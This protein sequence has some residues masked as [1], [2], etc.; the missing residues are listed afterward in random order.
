ML[1][2]FMTSNDLDAYLT[3]TDSQGNVLRRD[4]NSFGGT[5]SMIL[6]WASAGQTFD[7]GATASLGSQTGRYQVDVLYVAGD[8][9]P[10]CLPMG[11]LGAGTTQGIAECRFL[12]VH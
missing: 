12:S 2:L 4:D 10:G 11:N 9:P 6:Q 7:L 1:G 8:R 3:L 5:D